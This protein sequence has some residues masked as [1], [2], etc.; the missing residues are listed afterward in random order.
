MVMEGFRLASVARAQWR[1]AV[2]GWPGMECGVDRTAFLCKNS[3]GAL[4]SESESRTRPV[5]EKCRVA[6][7]DQCGGI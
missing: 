6:V 7:A 4:A 5:L 3:A 1:T 2:H